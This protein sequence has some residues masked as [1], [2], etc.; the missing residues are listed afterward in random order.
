MAASASGAEAG[1]WGGV[2]V[3]AWAAAHWGS[4]RDNIAAKVLKGWAAWR[5]AAGWRGVV[6]MA[7]RSLDSRAE[8]LAPGILG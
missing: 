4:V 1:A 7:R 6:V 3:D 5:R 8:V 2:G